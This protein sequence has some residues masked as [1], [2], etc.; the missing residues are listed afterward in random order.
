M[1]F[2]ITLQKHEEYSIFSTLFELSSKKSY[3]L[4][5]QTIPCCP[6]LVDL[7]RPPSFFLFHLGRANKTP[8]RSIDGPSGSTSKR[9][10]QK[11]NTF[12]I[13]KALI[14]TLNYIPPSRK[15]M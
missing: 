15:S 13:H 3:N 4:G 12:K 1:N 9:N 10:L 8:M 6:E 2:L 11:T 14:L 7:G 5:A